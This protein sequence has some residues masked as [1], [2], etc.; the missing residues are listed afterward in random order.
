MSPAP[1]V[2]SN[3]DNRATVPSGPLLY[4]YTADEIVEFPDLYPVIKAW[5]RNLHNAGI[6]NLITMAPVP[7][8]FR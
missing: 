1:S 4:N 6:L 2:G 5:A 8:L 7:E 3:S